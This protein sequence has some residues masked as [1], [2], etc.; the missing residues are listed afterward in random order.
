MQRPLF[1]VSTETQFEELRRNGSAEVREELVTRFSDLALRRARRYSD[2][3]E[4]LEDLQQVALIGLLKAIDRF[5]PAMEVPF[6]RFARPTIDGEIKRHFRDRTWRVAVPRRCKDL[7]GP[8]ADAVDRLHHRLGRTPEVHE[9]AAELS[10]DVDVVAETMSA[11]RLYRM[12]SLERLREWRGDAID[13][14]CSGGSAAE[15]P[16]ASDAVD[17][18]RVVEALRRLDG[19]T[20]RIVFW[21]FFEGCTQA[22]IGDRLG[23]GQVQ[24]SRLLRSAMR[25]LRSSVGGD[26][27]R[28]PAAS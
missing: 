4:S 16:L 13:P 23:I 19:R 15:L 11:N 26:E 2:R 25:Q 24:V 12:T 17:H 10:L 21:R 5:D 14:A 27:E 6:E 28:M 20:R 7:R 1:D 8:I 3:G 9:I 22:E 18:V